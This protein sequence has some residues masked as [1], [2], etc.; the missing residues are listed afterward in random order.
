MTR[1]I[2][3]VLANLM[4]FSLQAQ[5]LAPINFIHIGL[6]DGLSQSTVVDIAQDKQDNMWFATHNGLNKFDGYDFTVFLH[7]EQ[8]PHSI[9]NDVIRTCITDK[10][11]RIWAGTNEGLSLYDASQ[12]LFHNFSYQENGKKQPVDAIVEIDDKQFLLLVGTADK[13]LMLFD[14]D[15]RL[16]SQKALHAGLA[17]ISPTAINRQGDYIYIGSYQGLFIYSISDKTL[18]HLVPEKLVGK[19]ILAILQQ[20]PVILWIG[21][22]GDGLFRINP[23]TQE[24][25]Q[26]LH[27]EGKQNGIQSNYIRSLAVDVQGCLWI[28]TIN[29]LDI[30]NAKQNTFRSY[31]SNALEK[32]GL[33]QSS[34]RD[35]FM[36]SQ[37]GVWLGTY[38]GG[39]NYHHP[40]NERFHN[41]RFSPGINSLSDNIV[42][43]IREDKQKKIWIGTNNGGLNR[44][45]TQTGKFTHYTVADGLASNDVKYLHVDEANDCVYIGTHTGGLSILNRRTG[46]IETIKHREFRNIH[47]IEPTED[48][49]LWISGIS[50]FVRFN[51]RKRTFSNVTRQADGRP[52]LPEHI[53]AS[54]RDSKR[55]LWLGGESGLAVYT[56]EKGELTDCLLIPDSSAIQHKFINCIYESR[57][58]QFWI[59]TRS[60]LFGFDEKTGK[61]KHY[62]TRHGLSSNVVHGI[63]EDTSGKLWLSTNKGLN[64][65]QP[66]TEVFRYYTMDDG[67]A[68]NQFTNNACCRTTDGRMYFG[69]INGVTTFQPELLADNPYTPPVVITNLKVFNKTVSPGDET[70]ILKVDI[71][72]VGHITLPARYP[73]FSLDFVVSNYIS[74][75]HNTF[76][77]M[78]EGYDKEWYYTTKHRSVS[79]SNL[80][81]GNYN[82]L[83]KAANSDGKWNDN[84][85]VLKITILPVWYKTWWAVLLFFTAVV[86]L[87]GFIIRYFWMRK[88]MAAQIRMERIDKERQ[89]E[90]NEMKLRFFI[91]ISHELRTPLTM[92]LAPL[93]DVLDRVNDRWI[94]KQLE[95]VQRNTNRLLHLVNQLMDYRRAELGVF[96]LKVKYNDIHRVVEKNYLFYDK[97]ARHKRMAY[98][99]YSEVEGEKILCDPDYMELIVNN[100]LSNAFKYTAEGKSIDVILKTMDHELLLQVKD[101]GNGIPA[102]KQ[103]KIFDRFYQADNE[104]IGSGIGLSLVQRLV[105]L[106]HGRITLESVEGEG[107]VFSIYFP[108]C[109]S[110]YKPE[111]MAVA[112]NAEVKKPVHTTNSLDMYIADAE[113]ETDQ[114]TDSGEAETEQ[115]QKKEKLL[116]VEDNA[117]I[118]QYLADGLREK[119]Q[120]TTVENGEEA[121]VWMKE[122]EVDMILTDVMM[123]VMDGLQLCKQIKQNLNT[124]HIPVIILSAKTDFKEQMEGLNVGADDY[125]SKP[126]SLAMVQV[127]IK[128]LFRTR[129]RAIEFYSK[130]LEIEPEKI[131]LNPLDEELLKR[132][133]EVVESHIENVEFTTDRFAREM[134][135]SRSN[136]HLKMKALTG[137]PANEFI[138][139]LRFNKACKLLKEGKYTVAEI[140]GMVGYNTPSYFST[141]FKKYFGCL[142]SEYGK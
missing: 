12:E 57:S 41:I 134:C 117:E 2:L 62:T 118:R 60:G 49:E 96:A 73:M 42:G 52:L 130:S 30:Y 5:E 79:Y 47:I 40:L 116:I 46:H 87:T 121:L 86:A 80:P 33:S 75:E 100:L 137:E 18:T 99:F 84:P 124:S 119:Y 29:S 19:Q 104:H 92:I 6:N 138:R 16:F 129:Y 22:E 68:S 66:I 85:T 21:T 82:F 136:L 105:E 108:I 91:N 31:T 71:S 78:L 23:Q 51:P 120:V 55:R 64:Y 39:V 95:H 97:V 34:V 135:M 139:K 58:G 89:R 107:S 27:V 126:F 140:S 45:D 53:V 8:N 110:A 54:L 76:A 81:Q 88:N 9:E 59:G 24:I 127:K 131:A 56:E 77:Y 125:I 93:Q 98:N 28:G 25:T 102:D 111:E 43:C 38:F 48:D 13:Q 26:Y 3:Y 50:S 109:E 20:S 94:K 44:Y 63:Q 70:G 128:N 32:D 101:T 106:H 103:E 7:D 122:K 37:G 36:D 90:V 17:G 114:E 10:Q 61:M 69:N 132:A 115:E 72:D 4:I 113:N 67:L 142:P 11:G 123:P 83:V 14:T 35:I 15:T 74:G 133:V 141:S 1:Y 65:F 112:Q